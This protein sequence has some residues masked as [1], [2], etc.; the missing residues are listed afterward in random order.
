M[1][2]YKTILK[3]LTKVFT[4]AGWDV[5]TEDVVENALTTYRN[6]RICMTK[7]GQEVTA[8]R[9][10]QCGGR[11]YMLV[12]AT[13]NDLNGGFH[14]LYLGNNPELDIHA[15]IAKLLSD[16]DVAAADRAALATAKEDA[17]AEKAFHNLGETW[18]A[19]SKAIYDPWKDRSSEPAEVK[20]AHAE[21]T[22]KALTNLARDLGI[23]EQEI[24]DILHSGIPKLRGRID[25]LKKIYDLW[26][27]ARYPYTGYGQGGR[28]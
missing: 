26:F 13:Y 24:L 25:L 7:N 2:T 6:G 28:E 3:E 9:T 19:Y 5:V 10:S 17:E 8:K 1:A 15:E 27:E 12:T 18:G 11:Q 14:H 23:D 21:A 16:A 20:A 4:A 22:A